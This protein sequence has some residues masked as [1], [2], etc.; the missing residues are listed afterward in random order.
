M[1]PEKRAGSLRFKPLLP[2]FWNGYAE[3]E[4][5]TACIWRGLY[6]YTHIVL[7]EIEQVGIDVGIDH[8]VD[9]NTHRPPDVSIAS[10]HSLQVLLIIGEIHILRLFILNNGRNNES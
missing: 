7:I 2:E 6:A 1:N 9:N 3:G 8:A 10:I 4:T 5:D